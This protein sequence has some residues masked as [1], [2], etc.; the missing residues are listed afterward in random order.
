[1]D[2]GKIVEFGTYDELMVK[3]GK[4][5]EMIKSQNNSLE[6]KIVVYLETVEEIF[7]IHSKNN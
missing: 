2:E 3:E 7:Q 5:A 6:S 4:F 1:M